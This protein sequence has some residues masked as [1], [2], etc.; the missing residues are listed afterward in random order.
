LP[1]VFSR[2]SRHLASKLLWLKLA[3]ILTT[4]F[5]G[6]GNHTTYKNGD[7]WGMVYGM[8][9]PCGTW[10]ILS[11]NEDDMGFTIGR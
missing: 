9:L 4:H 11:N 3:A 7:D 6:N 10:D 2:F 5:P 1:Q 8:V